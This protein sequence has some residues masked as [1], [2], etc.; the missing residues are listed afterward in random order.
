MKQ[1]TLFLCW[2]LGLAW[3]MQAQVLTFTPF[4]PDSTVRMDLLSSYQPIVLQG[5]L[6]NNTARSI[7]VR[8]ERN[9]IQVPSAWSIQIQDVNRAY[10]DFV[11]SNI[12]PD[13]YL[14][15]PIILQ[16]R[17]RVPFN[18]F[19][20]PNGKAGSMLLSMELYL[21]DQ[22]EVIIAAEDIR[23]EV[24][25]NN[26][27][28]SAVFPNPS[29]DFMR[30]AQQEDVDRLVVYNI[31]GKKVKDFT[32]EDDERYNISD[33][34]DGIYLVGLFDDRNKIIRT[35]RVQKRSNRP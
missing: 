6:R 24:A 13:F 34:P 14:N 4:S 20:T 29:S 18:I 27:R 7:S 2:L 5:E 9:P 25:N 30:L 33:L 12:N 11:D 1:R 15:E 26:R 8:W 22:P 16:P 32:V 23:L 3:T 35:V 19:V 28:R 21:T 10:A 17:E 31:V